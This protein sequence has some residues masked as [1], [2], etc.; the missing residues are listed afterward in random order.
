MTTANTL[1]TQLTNLRQD[2]EKLH[3]P[4]STFAGIYITET[5]IELTLFGQETIVTA[6]EKNHGRRTSDL[7][8]EWLK[9]QAQQHHCKIIAA[10]IASSQPVAELTSRLWLEADIVPQ[11]YGDLIEVNQLASKVASDFDK[12]NVAAIYIDQRNEVIV[13]DDLVRLEDYETITT[14]TERTLL[15]KEVDSFKGKKLLFLSATPRGGGVALMR[16]A[17]IRLYRL[18]GVDA[19]WHVLLER[20]E[21]FDVT[22]T[23]FHNVLQAVSDPEIQLTEMDKAVY[24]AWIAEN[25]ELLTPVFA[26]ADV[27]GIDDPQPSG[28]VPFIRAANPR[29]KILYR[30]HIQ[31]ESALADMVGT[32]QHTTWQFIWDKIKD[33]D[34]F[35]THPIPHFIPAVVPQE[36]IVAMPPTTDPLD[37]LNKPLT[38]NQL[39]YYLTLFNKILRENTQTPLDTTRDYIV[40]IARFDPSKGIPDVLESYRQLR[41]KLE[42]ENKPVPQLVIVGHGS[43]DDPDGLPIYT[44]VRAMLEEDSYKE[45]ASDIKVARL[46][47]VDQLLNALLCQSKVALQLS[48]KE[49]FEI[50]VTEALMKGTPVISYRAGGIPLQIVNGEGGI[51]VDEIGN[52]EAVAKELYRLLTDEA[53]YQ[54][55]SQQASKNARTDVLTVPNAINWLY[56][57]NQVLQHGKLRTEGK[58]IRELLPLS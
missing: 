54:Q 1:V 14:S 31:I 53:Y 21:A 57:A 2:V 6:I 47:H 48:H 51:I 3:L 8:L 28:L 18:L 16:H 37:G 30:S 15:Q 10:G 40:Q 17:L 38:D 9:A 25:A 7:V 27:V 35:I 20:A 11:V 52:T 56:L 46:P 58:N 36:L 42:L 19:H 24:N 43:V 41:Q 33:T 55:M 23:K 34:G 4:I 29:V 5:D 26:E 12:E 39:D 45:M 13:A 49:G 22:K 44:L 32:P 50:K